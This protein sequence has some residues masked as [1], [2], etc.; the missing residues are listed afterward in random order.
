MVLAAPSSASWT[1]VKVPTLVSE[2]GQISGDSLKKAS[3]TDWILVQS[4]T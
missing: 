2:G 3:E 4:R 1:R